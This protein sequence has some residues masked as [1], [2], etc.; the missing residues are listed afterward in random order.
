MV[1]AENYMIVIEPEPTT[2]GGTVFVARHPELPEC[3]A[4]GA[5]AEEAER[6]LAEARELLLTELRRRGAPIPRARGIVG[7]VRWE[8]P[9]VTSAPSE[10][11]RLV[12][13]RSVGTLLR[14]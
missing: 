10:S 2:D 6:N 14:T 1:V 12:L 8:V 9:I 7:E 5:T 11:E 13:G 3:M 4:H